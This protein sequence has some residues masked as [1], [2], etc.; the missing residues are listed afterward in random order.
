MLDE[1]CR[2][3]ENGTMKTAFILFLII[4]LGIVGTA[5]YVFIRAIKSYL[6]TLKNKNTLEADKE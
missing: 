6:Q 3:T 1:G 5:L 2:F 4:G